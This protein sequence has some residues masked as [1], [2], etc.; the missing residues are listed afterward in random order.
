[1]EVFGRDKRSS[2]LFIVSVKSN[3]V[4]APVDILFQLSR[5][6]YI[7]YFLRLLLVRFSI[8]FMTYLIKLFSAATY[9]SIEI[10]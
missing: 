5:K 1:M 2:L 4:H 9:Y 8:R 7:W 3:V 6:S 10:S